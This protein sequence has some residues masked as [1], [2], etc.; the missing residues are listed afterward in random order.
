MTS[1][2]T[3]ILL[4]L[5]TLLFVVRLPVC[6]DCPTAPQSTS[7]ACAM[8]RLL[9]PCLTYNNN[10]YTKESLF[11]HLLLFNIEHFDLT[12]TCAS[13][14]S[15]LVVLTFIPLYFGPVPQPV[16]LHLPLLS[17]H[18]CWHLLFVVRL[19]VCDDCPTAPQ[20]TS[21]R[22]RL[23]VDYLLHVIL[24]TIKPLHHKENLFIPLLLFSIELYSTRTCTTTSTPS[25][26]Y[27]LPLL[28]FHL[29][30]LLTFT[31]C[32]KTPRLRWL[33]QCPTVDVD[34]LRY[35]STT[36][37]MLSYIDKTLAPQRE[38][39]YPSI[40][41]QHW[42]LQLEPV[43]Q[44]VL[45][46][47]ITCCL[48]FHSTFFTCWHLLFVVRLP[49][50]DDCPN[51]PQS[52]S[53]A[54]AMSRLLAPCYLT[55]DK[56]LAPQRELVYPSIALQHWTLQLEPVPQPVLPYPP[57]I[58]CCLYF[59]ST[60]FTCWHLLFVVRLPVCDDCPNAPQSTSTA[61]AMSRLL[62]MLSYIR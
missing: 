43:P 31:L 39:V 46:P 22:L 53:T 50:C 3:F 33:P 36:C 20:S 23:W 52:T 30:Y 41:L 59:H 17:F 35:E 15:L 11:N 62:A 9:A 16:T 47:F 19:P 60:F 4:Y 29:L 61:C 48:Y 14:P 21:D 38:L 42:T 55:Y 51:A 57:F 58:T 26:H 56:T 28:P 44:P 12:R 54:C 37:S 32:R 24:H 49:V 40:A 6:D 25:L 18:T 27:L 34:R 13:N 5:W 7:T 1:L 10:S 45:P 8:S 2:P